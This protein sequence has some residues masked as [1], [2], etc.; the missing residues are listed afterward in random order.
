MSAP[1]AGATA[2]A[3]SGDGALGAGAVANVNIDGGSSASKS[4]GGPFSGYVSLLLSFIPLFVLLV[5]LRS[6]YVHDAYGTLYQPL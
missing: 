5:A 4:S 1:G 3:V 2:A 6:W